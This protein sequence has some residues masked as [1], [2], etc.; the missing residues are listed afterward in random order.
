MPEM[1]SHLSIPL[2]A[3]LAF[4]VLMAIFITLKKRSLE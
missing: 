1:L 3:L 2:L 4:T